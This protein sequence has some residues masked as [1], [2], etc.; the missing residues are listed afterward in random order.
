MASWQEIIRRAIDGY[1]TP[2]YLFY[3]PEVLAAVRELSL[4]ESRLPIRNW[5]SFKTSPVAPLVRRWIALGGGV[6]VVR[7]YEFQAAIKEGCPPERI[8]VNGVG[9]Q[10]WLRR[11][12]L[13]RLNVVFDSVNEVRA[14]AVQAA[15]S[16]WTVGF[17]VH[18][19]NERD[20]DEMQHSTQFGM[21]REE[22]AVGVKIASDCGLMIDL[23]HFHLRSNVQHPKEYALAIKELAELT[24]DLRINPKTIDCGGGL[25]VSGERP[26]GSLDSDPSFSLSKFREVLDEVPELLPS[27]KEIWLENGR[28]ITARSGVL[29][30]K[31]IEI[32]QRVDSRFVVCDGGRTNHALVSDWENHDYFIHPARNGV[33]THTTIC[34]PTCMAFDRLVRAQL[35]SDIQVGDYIVWKNAGAYHIPW[36]TRFSGGLATVIWCDDEHTCVV[37]RK[38]ES[39]ESWWGQWDR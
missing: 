31:V 6:E 11:Y 19:A 36:E 24:S 38:A 30:L 5:L 4:L 20:P 12:S 25:P 17:R 33:L 8:L 16:E 21:T 32:K 22:I 34:G 28:F 10:S 18:V 1:E 13:P 3:W 14:M 39:F 15:Q 2:F 23:L 37:A 26:V 29:V 35:P 27:V 7:E 9:K